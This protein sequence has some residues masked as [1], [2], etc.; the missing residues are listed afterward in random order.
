MNKQLG[1]RA[2][3][4]AH[5]TSFAKS[6]CHRIDVASSKFGQRQLPRRHA[7]S[8]N[9]MEAASSVQPLHK[10]KMADGSGFLSPLSYVVANLL[11]FEGK[12]WV[13]KT[14]DRGTKTIFLCQVIRPMLSPKKQEKLIT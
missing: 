7:Q 1:R 2:S 3:S 14:C 13:I 12:G 5:A 11:I 4:I 9:G 10:D 6:K 8:K